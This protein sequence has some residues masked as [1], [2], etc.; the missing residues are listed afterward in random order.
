MQ[1]NE[2]TCVFSLAKVI[3]PPLFSQKKNF[4]FLSFFFPPPHFGQMQDDEED[5]GALAAVPEA[6]DEDEVCTFNVTVGVT[7]VH[8]ACMRCKVI[9]F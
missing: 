7:C 6:H 1:M 5:E 8:I 4:F 9:M 2:D 3:C